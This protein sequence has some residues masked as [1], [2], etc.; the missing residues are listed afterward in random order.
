ML[1][2]IA[3]IA[4][5]VVAGLG[6]PTRG[7]A[8][9]LSSYFGFEGLEVIA[10]DP[11]AGPIEAADMN[12]DALI[13]L[14]VVNN[15]KS[16]IEIHYQR[17]GATPN[18]I[19]RV[20]RVND[21]PEHWR[22]RRGTISVSHRITAVAPYDFD[23]DG[24]VDIVYAG[25][26]ATIAFMRQTEPGVFEMERR[27][28]VRDLG[29][30]RDGFVIAD[31]MGDAGAELLA[32]VGG[33]IHVWPLDEAAV[34]RPTE[35]AAGESMVAIMVEDFDG[36]GR[37]DVAGVIPEDA[38][39]V[40]LW[41][42]RTEG[43]LGVIGPQLR[44][45][46]P[47]LREGTSLRLPKDPAA[48]MA[49]IERASKRIVICGLA[50]EPISRAG[51]EASMRVH[52]FTDA[53]NRKRSVS[54]GDVDGDGLLDLVATDTES[55]SV[56][57]YRQVAGKGLQP[58]ESY[59]SYSELDF[60]TVANIDDDRDAEIF[61]LSESEGVVGRSDTSS[62]SVPFPRSMS[63]SG[64]MTPVTLN[65]VRLEDGPR[66]AII[67]KKGR[68]YVI[69]LIDM[70]GSRT[71]IELGSMSRTP[72]TVLDLDADQDGRVDLLLLT[73][74]KP[75]TMLRATDD[76]FETL[77]SD[78]MGQF[79]LV[80]AATTDN[81]APY[82]IDGDGRAELLIASNNFVRAVRYELAPSDGT[83]AGWQVVEQINAADGSADLVSLAILD[84]R[85]VAADKENNHLVLFERGADGAW[86]ELDVVDVEGFKFETIHAG[87]FSGD[88]ADNIL[89]VGDEGFAVI[90]LAGDRHVL[91]E[92]AT[93]RTDEE[94]RLHHELIS[95]DV[96]GDG[97]TDLVALDAGEQMCDI[98]TFSEA[99][100]LLHATGFQVFESKIFSGG[101]AREFEPSMGMIVDLTGDGADDLV[102]LAHDRVLLYPQM[103]R[104]GG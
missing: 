24:L 32:L 18:D 44:F 86:S 20:D 66:A 77:E 93:W 3:T 79:G 72:D 48:Y 22:F 75:M 27:H 12:G 13:D 96:N 76:G 40:R 54:V 30:G 65:L 46:M 62:G 63:V 80:K 58:G 73:R 14:L 59:P 94:R 33:A 64:G 38:A 88:A 103:T 50:S 85:I 7:Q 35:L 43:G 52:G 83:S 92:I 16:R 60:V 19:D 37:R 74:D 53:G 42:G 34:G 99:R 28:R 39:P 47:A 11:S 31:V 4:F 8:P 55:S 15:F 57:V 104:S 56:V 41:L 102:L 23:G 61:V 67:A 17:P 49:F 97:F 69:E 78:D 21:L 1:R 10:I 2:T 51:H 101:E 68:S 98:F 84:D 26:P 90:R 95:G 29:A 87:A 81:T 89:A 70:G 45:E 82:D 6:A 25:V 36:D 71:T 9:S 5:L 100:R 91:R